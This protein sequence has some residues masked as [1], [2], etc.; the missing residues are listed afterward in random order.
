[1]I[2]NQKY[3]FLYCFTDFAQRHIQQL[4]HTERYCFQTSAC[5]IWYTYMM[6]W[7]RPLGLWYKPSEKAFSKE[8]ITNLQHHFK[9]T[10][11]IMMLE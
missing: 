10:K 1:M 6:P 9:I 7:F 4:K 8:I 11:T 3:C 2:L 5:A